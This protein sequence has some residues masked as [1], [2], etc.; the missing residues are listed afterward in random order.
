MVNPSEFQSNNPRSFP[1]RGDSDLLFNVD[2]VNLLLTNNGVGEQKVSFCYFCSLEC[3]NCRKIL[4][5]ISN[6]T[7]LSLLQ[8]TDQNE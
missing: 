4:G 2:M 8:I 5:N 7:K 6:C 1:G 3:S